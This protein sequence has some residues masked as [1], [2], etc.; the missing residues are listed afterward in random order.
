MRGLGLIIAVM[1]YIDLLF[2]LT[3]LVI[4]KERGKPDLLRSQA[5][6]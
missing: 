1:P 2:A 4:D 6:S 3:D 5:E